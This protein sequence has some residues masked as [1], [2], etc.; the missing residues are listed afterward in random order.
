MTESFKNNQRIASY[1]RCGKLSDA[2]VL[3]LTVENFMKFN[4]VW[5]KNFA[6][7]FAQQTKGFF[8]WECFGC[9]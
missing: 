2:H 8:N 5:T 9:D 4:Y 3:P 7:K 1:Y 6:A